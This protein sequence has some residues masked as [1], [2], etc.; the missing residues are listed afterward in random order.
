MTSLALCV[1]MLFMSSSFSSSTDPA[2]APPAV[3]GSYQ[4]S[5]SEEETRFVELTNA[6]RLRLR[7]APLQIDPVLVEAARRHSREMAEK[8]YFSHESPTPELKTPMRRYL[9]ALGARPAY[10][11]VAENLFYCSRVDVNRGVK[12]LLESTYHREN[13]LNPAYEYVGVGIHEGKDGSFWVTQMFL[14]RTPPQEERPAVMA[15]SR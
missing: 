9:A 3:A 13:M 11:M 5:L 15:S 1:C 10:A 14:R 7:L 12:A 8:D 6:E 2:C 4:I